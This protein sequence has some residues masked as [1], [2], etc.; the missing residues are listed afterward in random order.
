MQQDGVSYRVLQCGTFRHAGDWQ[1]YREAV[2][3]RAQIGQSCRFNWHYGHLLSLF[4][5]FLHTDY[6]VPMI[7]MTDAR[8]SSTDICKE[9]IRVL[10]WNCSST[11]ENYGHQ[12]SR[13]SSQNL[14]RTPPPST[15]VKVS[16]F[17]DLI[18]A[19]IVVRHTVRCFEQCN[20]YFMRNYK[21]VMYTV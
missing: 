1:L 12:D 9:P 20:V 21:A 2:T 16:Y 8:K 3:L 7:K 11:D 18:D 4:K 19:H 5:L 6:T 14:K 15:N 17:T 13:C 10:S